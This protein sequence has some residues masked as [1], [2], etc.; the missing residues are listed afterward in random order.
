MRK[1]SVILFSLFL[2]VFA[3]A[4][5]T[6]REHVSFFKG[7][8]KS[9]KGGGFQY[10][11]PLPDVNSSLLIRSIDSAQYIEWETETIPAGTGETHITLIWMFGIDANTDRHDFRL[12]VNNQYCLTFSNPVISEKRP[13][14]IE[15]LHGTSLFFKPT[16][17]DKYN[18]PMGF[19]LLELPAGMIIPG[20]PQRIRIIG[21]S[22]NSRSWYMTFEAG[23]EE[24]TGITQVPALLRNEAGNAFPVLFNFLHTGEPVNGTI[25]ISGIP[26]TDFTLE[27]GY[28]E[29]QVL[30]PEDTPAGEHAAVITLAG[31]SPVTRNFTISPVRHFTIYLVQHTH[32]DIGYTRPQT[33]IL[34]DHLRYLDYALDFC[35]Q[36][37][38][39]PDDAR[40]RW[41]CE[42]SWAVREYLNTRP[43][44]QLERLRR[45]VNEG[46]IE[47]TALL[48]NASDLADETIIASTL[49]PVR[50][51]R[52][53][54]FP[55]KAA[56]QSDI[57][58]VPWCL[59]DYLPGIGVNYL[60]MAQNTHRA[61]KP[62]D[63][64]TVFWWE[65][66]S[67]NRLMV[68]RP[69]HYMFANTLGIL[70]NAET[71]GTGLFRH[72]QDITG[73][74]YPFDHYA[75]QFSGYLTD[76]APPSTTACALVDGW[77]KK[78]IWPKLRLATVSEFMDHVRQHHSDE[79]P[80]VRGAWPDWWMDGFGSATRQTAY[81]RTAHAD[82]IANEGLMSMAALMGALQPQKIN[83][84]R[85]QLTDDIA[86]YDEHTFG[87]AESIT[88]PQ[89][90]NSVVQLGQKESYVWSAVKKNRILREQ[91]M[92]QIQP[93][94][95]VSTLPTIAIFN[96][97]G[98]SRSG[99]TMVY[100][101]HQMIPQ[102]KKFK[103]TDVD[104]RSIPVQ[105]I[106]SRAEGA[107]WMLHVAEI[108]PMGVRLY[109][110]AG[111]TEPLEP[112]ADSTF[113][114]VFENRFYALEIDPE[115]GRVSRF[116]DK[117]WKKELTGRDNPVS[118]G[119]FIYERLGKNRGQLE[120][121]RLDEFTRTSWNNLKVSG[122]THGDVYGSIVLTGNLD[123]CADDSGIRCE[124][125]LY[126]H[127][128]KV[129]FSYSLIKQE[130]TDPEGIYV[131]FPFELAQG[132]HHVE[133]A[134]GTMVPGLEQ[135][136]GSASDW[137]GIQNF[138]SLRSD[139]GQ[140]VFV[141]PETPL[142]Q[143]GAL[144]LGNFSRVAKPVSGSI[145][146]WPLNNYWTTNFLASQ[147]GALNWTYH[148]TS[149][150][151]RSNA[152]ATRFGM[153]NRISMLNRVFPASSRAD[154]LLHPRSFLPA[155]PEN[156]ALVSTRPASGGSGV[157]M[158][159]R[160]TNGTPDSLAVNDVALSYVTLSWVQ[161]AVS[162]SEV[163]AIEEPVKLWWER[164][165]NTSG[166]Y[167]PV[168]IRFMPFETKFILITLK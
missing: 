4:Q 168:W 43:A 138:V 127:E 91:V 117:E 146:S 99:N 165:R 163:N 44:S 98:W 119:E 126:N 133:V 6:N 83:D 122:I 157:V 113:S 88:D 135:I 69:E 154:T 45:R 63:L 129:T 110:I 37:D 50:D 132:R 131:A 143:L 19:A 39:L 136:E 148:I 64:P 33:E 90:E 27:T 14:R 31:K 20:S 10:H 167:A 151:N 51:F 73:R 94:L 84:L 115:T 38:T 16:L 92:G 22:K 60:N 95:P 150:S 2:A 111:E 56:M 18:D 145:Y 97:L 141:S 96:T 28:N 93:H 72:L 125:R 89:C 160:E 144:N 78:Y 29:F 52:Q 112:S 107:W 128:K 155:L 30:M 59:A 106:S 24:K 100:I 121:Y 49:Q 82:Y 142:V 54:G 87:A 1:S 8:V 15:G 86:F 158:Q 104:G 120:Q 152:L 137:I 17:L 130:V 159:V 103:I 162:V 164:D 53:Q 35:D 67:G 42:T 124:I 12:Y 108:P 76:N 116:Y 3:T 21:D 5:S 123:E 161:L 79:L 58:G 57:N 147:E 32:T 13:W 25:E 65:S 156:L 81:A 48:L 71:F 134:G 7:Y 11:S 23:V 41:T 75:L 55:V 118:T 77:N 139:S 34:P 66:P 62:F 153:E 61:L 114:G 70:T 149:G 80:V 101:D 109:R 166:N 46:R 47:L 68:N 74:G 40:F 26:K 102:G 9:I 85:A 105:L 140:V 36:T